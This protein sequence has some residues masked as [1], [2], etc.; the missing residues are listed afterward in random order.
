MKPSSV[1]GKK[2]AL[3][4]T[5][6]FHASRCVPDCRPAIPNAHTAKQATNDANHRWMALCVSA[7]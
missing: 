7:R 3:A 5:T 6:S 2:L 4:K 1:A